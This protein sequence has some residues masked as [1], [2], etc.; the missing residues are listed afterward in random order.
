M[1]AVRH[2]ARIDTLELKLKIDRKLGPQKAEKY[3]NLLNRYLSGKIIKSEFDKV[4][5][6]LVGRESIRLHNELIKAILKNA[7][8][9]KTPPP[10]HSKIDGTLNVKVANGCQRSSL[11]SLCR[12][13]FP[14]SPRKG[15]TPNL[16]ERKFKDRPSPL[17][18][19]EKAHSVTEDLAQKVQE[20]QSATELFSL[21]SKPPVEVNSV[22]EGEEV[23]QAA[24]SPGI[25]SRSPVRAPLGISIHTKETRKVLRNGLA[26]AHYTSTCQNG[27]ELPDTSSLENRLKQKLGM[28]GLEISTDCVNL[29]NNGLDAFLKRV[30]KAGV[31]LPASR[32]K[33]KQQNQ[34]HYPATIGINGMLSYAL[35][36]NRPYSSSMLD[37]RVAMELNPRLLGVDWPVQ[38]EK[39]CLH[40]SEQSFGTDL[41]SKCRSK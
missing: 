22:E 15:R 5:I 29:L 14:Q 40:A 28:E 8:F 34:V 13:V 25:Y 23:E 2:V 38:L 27:G 24:I 16:R 39:V 36:P 1:P 33:F 41:A 21:G 18:L 30:I 17:G 12:D 7:Y 20:Q 35:K 6:G 31:E 4:C 10:K 37:F 11:Q 3:F 26:S 9:S 32:S 19:H